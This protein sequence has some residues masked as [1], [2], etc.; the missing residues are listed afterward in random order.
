M[1]KTLDLL[2]G[3]KIDRGEGGRRGRE[4][5]RG[6]GKDRGREGERNGQGHRER[7]G[8]EREMVVH[9]CGHS[10]RKVEA[11]GSWVLGQPRFQSET[12]SQENSPVTIPFVM[13]HEQGQ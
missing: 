4:K 13:S 9:I 7:K 2:P 1:Y 12:L 10:T 5:E 11:G 6:K 8:K 3:R